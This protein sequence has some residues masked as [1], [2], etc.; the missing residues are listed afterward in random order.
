MS[1][2]D[3]DRAVAWCRR[4]QI[5]AAAHLRPQIIS[6]GHGGCVVFPCPRRLAV[7]GLSDAAMEELFYEYPEV[8]K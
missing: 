1:A 3:R 8:F 5:W 7:L 6:A 4:T 2:V